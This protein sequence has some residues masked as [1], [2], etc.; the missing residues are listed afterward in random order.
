MTNAYG[1]YIK[2]KRSSRRTTL[3]ADAFKAKDA[4][5]AESSSRKSKESYL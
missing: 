3:G 4:P 2:P 1:V 5:Q